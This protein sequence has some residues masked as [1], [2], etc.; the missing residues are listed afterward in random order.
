[1]KTLDSVVDDYRKRVKLHLTE[2][3]SPGISYDDSENKYWRGHKLVDGRGWCDARRL[4]KW[5]QTL[6]FMPNN[7]EYGP[8]AAK[9]N[10]KYDPQLTESFE[11]W[12]NDYYDY[13]LFIGDTT[14]VG[15]N[16]WYHIS[17]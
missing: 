1:M 15:D 5:D 6:K 3:S 13:L 2:V 17:K 12:L 14:E 9:W 7:F 4:K 10:L 8:L 16:L 11:K